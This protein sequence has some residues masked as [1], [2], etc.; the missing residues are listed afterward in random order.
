MLIVGRLRW[1]TRE[2]VKPDPETPGKMVFAGEKTILQ[3]LDMETLQWRDVP[4]LLEK[5]IVEL[6]R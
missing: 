2:Y 5:E 4:H 3:Y 1:L 6:P